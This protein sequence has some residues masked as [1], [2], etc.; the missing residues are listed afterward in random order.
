LP[1]AA[2]ARAPRTIQEQLLDR[3]ELEE[4]QPVADQGHAPHLPAG[5]LH[6]VGLHDEVHLRLAAEPEEV[7][8]DA[9]GVKFAQDPRLLGQVGL[10]LVEVRDGSRRVQ[11]HE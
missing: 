4:E 1:S 10:D 11:V 3:L 8:H 5:L 2:P 6:V 7:L 9:L